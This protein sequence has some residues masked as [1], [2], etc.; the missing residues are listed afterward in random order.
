MRSSSRVRAEDYLVTSMLLVHVYTPLVDENA[1]LYMSY[2][3]HDHISD[4]SGPKLEA[5][6]DRT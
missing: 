4:P 6:P 2:F 3:Y 1:I 5:I